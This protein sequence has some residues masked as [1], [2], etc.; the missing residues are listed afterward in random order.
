MK[1]LYGPRIR[2]E[3]V[4]GKREVVL[5]GSSR[6]VSAT[7]CFSRPYAEIGADGW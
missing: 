7:S 6:M 3:S 1:R 4:Y 2:L 5:K